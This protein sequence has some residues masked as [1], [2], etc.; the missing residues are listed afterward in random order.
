MSDNK[1][2]LYESL[3]RLS[4]LVVF[5]FALVA[6]T[7]GVLSICQMLIKNEMRNSEFVTRDLS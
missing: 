2:E 4:L 5:M 3:V 7:F 1:V 6:G